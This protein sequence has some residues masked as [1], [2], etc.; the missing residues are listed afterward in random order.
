[1]LG[2]R[3]EPRDP[4]PVL[5][6]TRNMTMLRKEKIILKDDTE[7]WEYYEYLENLY[8]FFDP[9]SLTADEKYNNSNIVP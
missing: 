8:I 1:M 9:S 3:T 2:E 7:T 4:T 6:H 5:I